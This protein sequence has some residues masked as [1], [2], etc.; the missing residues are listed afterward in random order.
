MTITEALA[1]TRTI[2]KRIASKRSFVI[3]YLMRMDN[4]KDPLEKDG[5]AP[6]VIAQEMQAIADLENR[7]VEIRR[8]ISKANEDT[9]ITIEGMEKSIADWLVW[10]REVSP[11]RQ[12]FF[13]QLRS[14]LEQVRSVARREG[15]S[16]YGPDAKPEKATDIVVNIGEQD[17]AK[18]SER[19]E[20]I[21]GQLDGLLSLKNATIQLS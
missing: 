5:G 13:K 11:D 2:A 18:E 10:R 21:L 15:S 16:M 4:V 14:K 19:I 9:K 8:Q 20:S 3:Q 6:K 12:Q 1:E 7:L 17:L